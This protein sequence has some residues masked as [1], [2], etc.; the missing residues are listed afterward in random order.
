M[1]PWKQASCRRNL[2]VASGSHF[3]DVVDQTGLFAPSLP[4]LTFGLAF[5]DYDGDGFKDIVTANGPQRLHVP[6]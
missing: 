2:E 1:M 4:L 6:P 5:V 3:T